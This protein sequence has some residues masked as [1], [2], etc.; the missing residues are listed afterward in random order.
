[1]NHTI[2]F[3]PS[4][5]LFHVFSLP[6][7]I[8]FSISFIAPHPTLTFY[9][10]CVC[11]KLIV[12]RLFPIQSNRA[13]LCFSHNNFILCCFHS[14]VP[15]ISFFS[16]SYNFHLMLSLSKSIWLHHSSFLQTHSLKE[17]CSLLY[18]WNKKVHWLWILCKLF[19]FSFIHSHLY[20]LL[21]VLSVFSLTFC[22]LIWASQYITALRRCVRSIIFIPLVFFL[23]SRIVVAWIIF[24]CSHSI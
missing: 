13:F 24:W 21:F 10:W 17:F 8:S 2:H 1:M 7:T 22:S 6:L 3:I 19:S 12:V 5:H 23:H 4:T 11:H 15:G 16:F 9:F 20:L 14:F 18:C